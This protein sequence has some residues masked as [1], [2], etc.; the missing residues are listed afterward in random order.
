M[1]F[2]DGFFI[3]NPAFRR[4]DIL[5][6]DGHVKNT[7]PGQEKSD[8]SKENTPFFIKKIRIWLLCPLKRFILYADFKLFF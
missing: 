4:V 2:L 3:A 7:H 5:Q 1:D 6:L 8:I